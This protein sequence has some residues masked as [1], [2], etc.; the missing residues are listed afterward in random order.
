MQ[1]NTH[2]VPGKVSF[3]KGFLF[4]ISGNFTIVA[5]FLLYQLHTFFCFNSIFFFSFEGA[6]YFTLHFCR[7]AKCPSVP[8]GPV[9]SR[10]TN[11][12]CSAAEKGANSAGRMITRIQ[13]KMKRTKPG[14]DKDCRV[15]FF[16]IHSTM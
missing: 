14:K 13:R 8:A 12:H 2:V 15:I 3:K 1:I 16:K 4:S 7:A 6:Q 10:R 9:G 11:P 5:L